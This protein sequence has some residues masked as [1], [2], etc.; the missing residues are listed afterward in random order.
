MGFP[1]KK[2]QETGTNLK[3]ILIT[4]GTHEKGFERLLNLCSKLKKFEISV[5][6]GAS[7][8]SEF[9]E[10]MRDKFDYAPQSKLMELAL[11]SRFVIS[12]ASP[13]SAELA[14]TSNSIYVALPREKKFAEAVDDHQID[15]AEMLETYGACINLRNEYLC[16]ELLLNLLKRERN[17]LNMQKVFQTK[18]ET[19]KIKMSL[20]ISQ[21]LE[22]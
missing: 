1:T 8:M 5:Q 6:Y 17:I 13:G 16:D 22:K 18:L 4:V 11:N 19:A 14:W 2:L 3:K 15:F 7:S 12:S 20:L 21:N 9:N 10:N